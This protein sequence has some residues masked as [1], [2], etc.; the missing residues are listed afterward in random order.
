MELRQAYS[1]LPKAQ[2]SIS[3]TLEHF[4]CS[5]RDKLEDGE[6]RMIERER[7]LIGEK[8]MIFLEFKVL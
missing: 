8:N 1:K 3:V 7:L 4:F 2:M 6:K 5:E